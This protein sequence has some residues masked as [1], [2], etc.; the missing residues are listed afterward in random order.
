MR[1]LLPTA[2]ALV[3]LLA[4][5][6]RP[7]PTRIGAVMDVEWLTNWPTAGD[8]LKHIDLDYTD[9]YRD[10]F[11]IPSAAQVDGGHFTFRFKL[12]DPL[13]KG[14][15]FRYKVYYQNTSYKFPEADAAGEQHPQAAENFYGSWED[16]GEGFRPTPPI[17]DVDGTWITDRLLIHGDPRDEP[18]YVVD[19]QRQRKGRNPRVGRYRFL[20]VVVP[21]ERFAQ[22]VVPQPLQDIRIGPDGR[23]IEPFWYFLHGRGAHAQEVDVRVS[24][25]VLAVR[26]RPEVMR[27][28]YAEADAGRRDAFCA[29]CGDAP[30]L[31][32]GAAWQQHI[33][34]IDPTARFANIPVV[35][36]PVTYTY[37]DYC[38]NRAFTPPGNM[39]PTLPS[40]TDR[41]CSTVRLDSA[42]QAIE[43]R[44]P[45]TPRGEYRKENVGVR[46]R[47]ALTY[48]RY[49]VRCE[50]PRLLNDGDL[51]NGLTNAV[52]LVG[53]YAPWAR[54]RPCD[55]GYLASYDGGK[56]DHRVE[57][58][59]YAE[60]DFEILKT[61]PYCPQTG[62][63]PN[64]A[65]PI[66][67]R[68]DDSRWRVPLPPDVEALKGR[69]TVAC[70]NWDMACPQ[71][72]DFGV[73]CRPVA[74]DG[75]T[76]WNFRWDHDY[77]AV[78]QKVQEPDAE[79]FGRPYWFEIDWRPTEILWRIGP[80]LDH[81]RLVGYMNDRV[82]SI[83]EVP[84]QLI[85]SQEYHSTTWW[86]GSPYEQGFLPFPDKDH[87]G[88]V[89]EVIID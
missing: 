21:E 76:F 9:A 31:R 85:V 69:I 18:Q 52:W 62:F 60:I 63:P 77:R 13:G 4:G 5:C 83:P 50:L 51:W 53:E 58:S 37:T 11:T 82:T 61:V 30:A 55:G 46:T 3:L 88:R 42:R 54:R 8:G 59:N 26:A 68:T 1:L 78:T 87:V 65:Q 48:G 27:G 39:V 45:A 44:N 19:G 79:L 73:G 29:S 34:R 23:Y 66:A 75:R 22:G 35:T 81:L 17:T 6:S 12:R 74:Y 70:T 20:L 36:D 28:V 25:D 32:D 47:H 56:G 43:L 14:R 2:L 49:R 72:A 64:Y 16:A 40:V 10:G 80:D 71:P 67:S 57:R 24:D 41:P 84:M 89:L 7:G 86:P 38:F 15:T 33:H